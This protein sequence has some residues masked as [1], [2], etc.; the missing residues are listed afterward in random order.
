MIVLYLVV[1][2][3]KT[4]TSNLTLLHNR[5][6]NILALWGRGPGAV[7]DGWPLGPVEFVAMGLATWNT[8]LLDGA[9]DVL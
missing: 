5:S 1:L 7:D 4:G 6:Q 8:R 2:G 3:P 9:D